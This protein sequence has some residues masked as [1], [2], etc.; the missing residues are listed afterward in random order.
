MSVAA[1]LGLGAGLIG[2]GPPGETSRR[3]SDA[4]AFAA[5][6]MAADAGIQ[7]IDLAAQRPDAERVLGEVL[8]TSP[9]L[10]IVLK[11]DPGLE[12]AEALERGARA[13]LQRLGRDRVHALVVQNPA[14]L[15]GDDGPAIWDRMRRLKDEGRIEAIGICACVCDD[16]LGLARRFKPDLM[17]L[18]A[19]LLDQRLIADG[20]LGEIAALGVHIH[21]RSIFMQGLLFLAGH[22]LPADMA[23]MTPGLSRIRLILAQAGAD[24]LQAAL[25]FALS[26][27]EVSTVI[28]GVTSPSELRAALAAASAPPPELDWSALA[29]NPPCL[30]GAQRC[31]A[32]A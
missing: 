24:P 23:A 11:T 10:R 17:Q 21:L 20:T 27:A 5:V 18:P 1:R 13:A 3:M 2:R 29:L 6:A 26:R 9:A 14:S 7:V 8:P 19:S 4:E 12:T 25:A 31:L 22:E 15:L 16:P 28:I 32:A 30:A